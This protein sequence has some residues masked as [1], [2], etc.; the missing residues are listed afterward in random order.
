[1]LT[2]NIASAQSLDSYRVSRQNETVVDN[3]LHQYVIHGDVKGLRNYL[4]GSAT[5]ANAASCIV[6]TAGKVSTINKP[7]PLIFDVA[8][9]CLD[10]NCPTEMF[11]AVL[12]TGADMYVPYNEKTV[13]YVVLE[14]IATMPVEFC[15]TA[16]ELLRLMTK[17]QLRINSRY[18]Q[19]PPPFTYLIRRT[20]EFNGGYSKDYVSDNVIHMMLQAGANINAYDKDDNT[21]LDFAIATGND[22]LRIFFIK[23]GVDVRHNTKAGT[24]TLREAIAS[25]NYQAVKEMEEYGNANIDINSLENNTREISRYPDLYQYLAHICSFKAEI[26]E[27][28][29]LFRSRFPD[30]KDMVKEKYENHCRREVNESVTFAD[31]LKCEYRYPDLTE[32]T[33]PKKL[34]IYHS[35]CNKLHICLN[36]TLASIGGRSSF[37]D[38]EIIFEDDDIVQYFINNYRNSNYDPDGKLYIAEEL[39]GLT[40][41]REAVEMRI[42]SYFSVHKYTIAY[43][44]GLVPSPT[45]PVFDHA[46][47]RHDYNTI[48][49]AL[50]FVHNLD[51]K[52]GFGDFCVEITPYLNN[53][54]TRFMERANHEIELYNAA[55]DEYNLKVEEHQRLMADARRRAEVQREQERENERIAEENRKQEE[56]VK[57]ETERKKMDDLVNSYDFPAYKMD[58]DWRYFNMMD[59]MV[60]FPFGDKI[61][62][63]YSCVV[64]YDDGERGCIARSEDYKIFYAEASGKG[65]ETIKDALAAEYFYQKYSIVREKGKK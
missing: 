51:S 31:I 2:S 13:I 15:S 64:E 59:A 8:Y 6:A 28:L 11:E 34:S 63:T 54:L 32:I 62:G 19:L 33:A 46:G 29:V 50:N 40:L 57:Q 56:Q 58:G 18:A 61:P 10:G 47:C 44:L 45:K 16:E 9:N 42:R 49:A 24:N 21:L 22:R 26:Y 23:K 53:K 65:Y 27:D 35:D 12:A 60:A 38:G 52:C 43:F 39:M 41:V 37:R 4:G 17:Y 55:V 36:R 20:K 48:E 14:R 30:K 1:M 5:K 7:M 25:G 3:D